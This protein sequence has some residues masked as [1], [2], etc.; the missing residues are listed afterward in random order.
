MD[1]SEGLVQGS[2][3]SSSGF[4]YTIHE[5][6]KKAN[7]R[8]VKCGGCA[9]FG[10]DD[11][12]MIGPK[13]VVFQVLRDFAQEIKEE[14]GCMLNTRKCKMYTGNEGICQRAKEEGWIPTEL[15]LLEEGSIVD[16]LGIRRRGIEIFN[17]LVGEE[18]YVAMVLREKAKKVEKTTR[19]YVEELE[20]KYP[21]ELWTMLQF[22][23][24]HRVTYWLRTC[25]PEETTEMEAH[26]D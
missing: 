22:S 12:Y 3:T 25:T 13:E 2:P 4:S 14:H 20:E 21:H 7:R 8:L 1:Y 15:E 9:R 5:N 11:G 19:R 26:V 16:D 24:Q 17:V 6:V 18:E 23:L 10:M